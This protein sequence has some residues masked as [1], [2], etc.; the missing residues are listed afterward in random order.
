MGLHPMLVWIAPL[1][2]EW[3]NP[4][5]Q[6]SVTFGYSNVVCEGSG[7][8]V[9]AIE[10]QSSVL[11]VAIWLNSL[12][13]KLFLGGHGAPLTLGYM[14]LTYRFKVSHKGTASVP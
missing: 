1:A 4:A 9:P 3:Q 5:S 8:R 7:S 6:K 2:L 12:R 13:S 10:F 11:D 14:S